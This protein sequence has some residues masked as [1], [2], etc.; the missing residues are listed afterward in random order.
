LAGEL[1][2][3]LGADP[4]L[5]RRGGGGGLGESGPVSSSEKGSP[6]VSPL[7][8]RGGGGGGGSSSSSASWIASAPSSYSPSGARRKESRR[9]L[10]LW[11]ILGPP[12]RLNELM[13]PNESPSPAPL[14]NDLPRRIAGS[15]ERIEKE[16]LRPRPRMLGGTGSRPAFAIRQRRRH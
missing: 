4:W 3:E 13:R 2:A 11:I 7:V 12:I 9:K 14:P 8:R 1:G 15:E 10:S 16:M 6:L 5:E